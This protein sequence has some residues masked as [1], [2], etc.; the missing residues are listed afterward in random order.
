MVTGTRCHPGDAVR[1]E[2]RF[3]PGWQDIIQLRADC[4]VG[5]RGERVLHRGNSKRK[6]A[7][8][9]EYGVCG[10]FLVRAV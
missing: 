9:G 10:D 6:G 3:K 2:L 4:R 5:L 7:K 1:V 8:V